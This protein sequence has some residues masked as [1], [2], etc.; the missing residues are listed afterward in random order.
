MKTI[1][2]SA[3]TLVLSM[4]QLFA[5]SD[6]YTQAMTTTVDALNQ[7]EGK[8]PDMAAYQELANRFERIATAEPKEWLP[9]YHAAYCYTMLGVMGDD[10]TQKEQRLDKAE[11]MLKE[12][13]TLDGQ[14][15]DEVEVLKAFVAQG[16][17]AIDPMSRW[18]TYGAVFG[19][20][21]AAA[22]A[23]NAD[24]PRIYVLEGTSLFYTPEQFGGGK[25]VAKPLFE[26]A[27]EKFATFKSP[28]ATYPQWGKGQ[29][30]WMA[31]QCNQ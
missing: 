2:I 28:G 18:Q 4:T 30:E 26:K 13:E 31:A 23:A 17:L 22:K 24:N 5:Q 6:K 9:R 20:H 10:A 11:A 25:K 3:L 21:L 12:V 15:D 19:E 29:A 7:Q 8:Q 16:R 1:F 27:L 14:P